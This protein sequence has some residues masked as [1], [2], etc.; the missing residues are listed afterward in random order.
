MIHHANLLENAMR[1]RNLLFKANGILIIP[2]PCHPDIARHARVIDLSFFGF[3]S[4]TVYK[5]EL[6]IF[7]RIAVSA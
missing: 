7:D 1:T 4:E 2:D 5:R 3:P 6:C